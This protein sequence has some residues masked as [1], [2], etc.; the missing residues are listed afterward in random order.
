LYAFRFVYFRE[1]DLHFA[2]FCLSILVANS[3]F[4]K[5]NYLLFTPKNLLFDDYFALF[6]PAFH[7]LRRFYLYRRSGYLCFLP[8]I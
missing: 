1:K 4:F 7:G 2:P 6:G 8:R 3:K 5:P